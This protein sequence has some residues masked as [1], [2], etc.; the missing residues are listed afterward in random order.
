MLFTFIVSEKSVFVNAKMFP[1]LKFFLKLYQITQILL[2]FA[3]FEHY[4]CHNDGRHD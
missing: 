4:P 2:V 1:F 3:V